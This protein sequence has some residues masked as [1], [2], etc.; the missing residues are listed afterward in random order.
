MI[1][2]FPVGQS[3]VRMLLE[4]S[5]KR[6]RLAHAY[7]FHGPKGTGKD[8]MAVFLTLT[9]N[10]KSGKTGGCGEC[11][12]CLQILQLNYPHVH[13]IV[14]APTRPRGMDETDYLKTIRESVLNW[15]DNPH[16]E[17]VFPS[18]MNTLPVIS[19]DQ[20]RTLKKEMVLRIQE[21][22]TRVIILSRADRMTDSAANSLLKILEEPPERTVLIL[23]SH[24]P[25]LLLETI[26]SRCQKIRFHLLPEKDIYTA[27][28]DRWNVEDGRARLLARMAGGSMQ[29]ALQLNNEA[30]LTQRQEAVRFFETA[31]LG[32]EM[33]RIELT[34][35]FTQGGEKTQ[36]QEM[37][38]LL[39]IWLRDLGH[40]RRG[41][42]QLIMNI[43]HEDILTRWSRQWSGN[44][45]DE[46]VVHVERAIDLI[47]KNVY[48]PLVLMTLSGQLKAGFGC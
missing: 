34:E 40:W 28:K 18:E 12:S 47:E 22:L 10:C 5:I 16:M 4:N 15:I 39:I 27:L 11:S 45:T 30:F 21:G 17:V 20:I 37:L 26:V 36:V 3:R 8:A 32:S 9:L 19:I 43:D 1:W 14:P 41:S 35:K 25:G 6:H 33:D 2:D 31:L 46:S 24:Q 29:R 42:C 23:T 38:Y 13:W 48:L 7:L 44:K